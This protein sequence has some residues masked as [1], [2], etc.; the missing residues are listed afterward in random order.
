[1]MPPPRPPSLAQC[2]LRIRLRDGRGQSV[3][4]LP[5]RARKSR[6]FAPPSPLPE[7]RQERQWRPG[8][9]RLS[10]GPGTGLAH[11]LCG[12]FQPGAGLGAAPSAPPNLY[13]SDEKATYVY[14]HR[15]G[16]AG[17]ALT[18]TGLPGEGAGGGSLSGHVFYD[19]NRNGE[20]QAGEAGVEVLL[21]GRYRTLTD[22][23]GRFEF[24]RVTTGH[25][26]LTLTPESVPPPWGTA[27]DLGGLALATG[28]ALAE[29]LP[30]PAIP[31]TGIGKAVNVV[32]TAFTNLATPHGGHLY[33]PGHLHGQHALSLLSALMGMPPAQAPGPGSTATSLASSACAH[34]E[35][36]MTGLNTCPQPWWRC[37][38][39]RPSS[40]AMCTSPQWTMAMMTG[41]RSMPLAHAGFHE[42]A[43]PVR[44]HGARD[45]QPLLEIVKAA[46]AEKTVAQYQQGPAVADDRHRPGHRAALL[47]EIIPLHV[48]N[49]SPCAR[50]C[51]TR[52]VFELKF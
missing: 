2:H 29:N 26:Q 34:S 14:L 20:R 17:K 43:E 52:S 13:R 44:K 25:H 46:H 1:M 8:F 15:E 23:D 37:S 24:P 35:Q 4:G 32:A 48:A 38:S 40:P 9:S 27:E 5:G 41:C 12:A 51:L 6:P 47:I 7:R 28:P 30:A 50:P 49:V 22:R 39:G 33:G 3:S 42:L 10:C 31:N 18:A 11:G 45:A 36:T 16:S 21:D 19:A